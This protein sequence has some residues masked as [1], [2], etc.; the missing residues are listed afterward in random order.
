MNLGSGDRVLV[1]GASGFI[2]S[3]VT[4]QLVARE[5]EVIALVEPGADTGNLD[6]SRRQAGGR[7]PAGRRQRQEGRQR[8]PGGLPRRR[9]LPVLG[10]RPRRLLRHQRGWDQEHPRR[11]L[12]VRGRAPGVHEHGR[13]PRARARLGGA[14][15]RRALVPRRAAPLRLLQ[16]LQVRGRA[17]G[18]AR[19][20]RGAARLAGP[21]DLPRRSRRPR[22]DADRQARPRLSERPDPRVR[23][24]GAERRAR[25]RRG[26]RARPRP[27][28]GAGPGAAT[29]W[30]ART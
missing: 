30:V 27:R 23:Q 20:R 29:S 15:G 2:G 19:H 9:S 7:G 12:G 10:E 26:G 16:A 18:A 1:T 24:H 11:G 22:A 8:L 5:Q 6:G 14:V 28:A 17:R 21:P 13:D 25:R 4:R 3:A